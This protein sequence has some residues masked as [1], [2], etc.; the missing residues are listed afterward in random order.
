MT[1]TDQIKE[2]YGTLKRFARLQNLSVQ[3]LYMTLNGYPRTVV[4]KVLVA[5]GYIESIDDL[6]AVT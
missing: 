1:L 5:L 4:V 2:D 6:R 3:S